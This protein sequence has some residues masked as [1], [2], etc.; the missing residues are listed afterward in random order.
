VAVV[1]HVCGGTSSFLNRGMQQDESDSGARTDYRR[2]SQLL[3]ECVS[4]PL[5]PI[6]GAQFHTESD[7]QTRFVQT[8]LRRI[9]LLIYRIVGNVD[10][11]Q[12]LTQ[13]TF[14]KALQRQSQLKDLD[15]AAQWLSRIA[16]NTAIDFLRRNKKCDFTDVSELGEGGPA[17][18]DSPEQLLLRGE[19]KLQLDGGL[20]A[21][22]ARE[23][24]ALLL[25]DVEDMP[26]DEV[27]RQMNCSM[28]TVRSHIANA[29]IKFKRY[30]EARKSS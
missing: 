24:M 15:K 7:A 30:L 18:M 19:R 22:T 6:P 21:L 11:A 28:A 14:I 16:S 26:A 9:F 17:A 3:E 8:H 4:E 5:P 25:R 2:R 12:D 1:L 10:D 27:A 29:R 13:E 23:R 20:A